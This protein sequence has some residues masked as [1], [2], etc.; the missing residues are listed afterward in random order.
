MFRCTM[1]SWAWTCVRSQTASA[2]ARAHV[3]CL[4]ACSQ[5][6]Y[7]GHGHRGQHRVES[8]DLVE[9]HE[10]KEAQ[11]GV[12]PHIAAAQLIVEGARLAGLLRL[13]ASRRRLKLHAV[14]AEWTQDR[15][16]Q[17][18]DQDN[19]MGGLHAPQAQDQPKG[20]SDVSIDPIPFAAFGARG[21]AA[22][23]HHERVRKCTTRGGRGKRGRGVTRSWTHV[24]APALG[25]ARLAGALVA[26]HKTA[27]RNLEQAFWLAAGLPFQGLGQVVAPVCLQPL[28]AGAIAPRAQ[29]TLQ[30]LPVARLG[31][32][33][34]EWARGVPADQ[35]TAHGKKELTVRGERVRI[36]CGL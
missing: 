9:L 20:A 30:Q 36:L 6:Q 11:L 4:G 35:G 13:H 25:E 8:N 14:V 26:A 10:R 16:G 29:R 7:Y 31:P 3:V 21:L 12:R 18:G 19:G 15:A 23:D 27:A 24:G 28:R 1:M 33:A 32:P 2:V 17:I 5:C 34:R 22:V